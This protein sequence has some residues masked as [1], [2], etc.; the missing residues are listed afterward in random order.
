[1][2]PS[3]YKATTVTFNN[4][5]KCPMLGLGTW[6]VLNL[7]HYFFYLLPNYDRY[8]SLCILVVTLT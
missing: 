8:I 2:E 4:G 6:Q 3:E 7:E 5:Q 1:M